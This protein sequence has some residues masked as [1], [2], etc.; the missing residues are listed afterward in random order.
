MEDLNIYCLGLPNAG[1][2]TLTEAFT[3]CNF[4]KRDTSH[5]HIFVIDKYYTGKPTEEQID[6]DL[7]ICT[8]NNNNNFFPQNFRIVL[9]DTVGVNKKHLRNI[10]SHQTIEN[11]NKDVSNCDI[12][13]SIID[14]NISDEDLL[15]NLEIIKC[16][17]E[18]LNEYALHVCIINKCDGLIC[19]VD[20]TFCMAPDILSNYDRIQKQLK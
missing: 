15:K 11:F 5:E 18:K 17:K 4:Y 2:S 13:L 19:L 20:G 3:G 16:T 12:L 14:V 8:L 6:D 10:K 9:H 7:S 1:K